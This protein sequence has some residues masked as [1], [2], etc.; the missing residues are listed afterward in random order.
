MG[1]GW[2]S[3]LGIG[4]GAFCEAKS[5]IAN[6]VLTECQP[7]RSFRALFQHQARLVQANRAA[8]LALRSGRSLASSRYLGLNFIASLL[9]LRQLEQARHDIAKIRTGVDLVPC[10]T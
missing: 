2:Q 6:A 4:R 7:G 1:H 8:A 10:G 9:R 5:A 3:L